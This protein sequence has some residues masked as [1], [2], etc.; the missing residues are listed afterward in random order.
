MANTLAWR[1]KPGDLVEF[2]SLD[3][4]AWLLPLYNPYGGGRIVGWIDT[5]KDAGLVVA[6]TPFNEV[7]VLTSFGCLGLMHVDKL[8]FVQRQR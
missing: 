8:R 2:V 5:R 4:A 7:L 6:L 3:D 1:I